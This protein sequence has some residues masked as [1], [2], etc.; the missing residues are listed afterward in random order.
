LRGVVVAGLFAA[1][2]STICT[3]LNT[4]AAYLINDV[5]KRFMVPN[6]DTKHYVRVGRVATIGVMIVGGYM[7]TVS[8][9]ILDLSQMMA[10]F[11]G[12]VGALFVLRWFWWRINAWSEITAY[13]S[14]GTLGMLVNLEAG[15]S[16][17][18]RVVGGLA[19]AS[20]TAKI[21][22]FFM[23]TLTGP[24]GWAFKLA[25]IA[26]L[27]T[28]ISLAVTLLTPPTEQAHLHRFY[29]IVKPYGPGW[30][31]VRRECGPVALH[32]GQVL[33]DWRRLAWGTVFFFSTFW[34]V[35]QLTLGNWKE[36]FMAGLFMAVSGGFLYRHWSRMKE[37]D[38][39]LP[40][41]ID[42]GLARAVVTPP[43]QTTSER[44]SD[45]KLS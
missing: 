21:D 4:N 20:A 10:Q 25:F 19:P 38:P 11:T 18:H 34:T 12:G 9:S 28:V 43:D 7:A 22:Q 2:M 5:Y 40:E 26:M 33:F 39:N 44:R 37:A 14:S 41:L 31:K 32:P 13:L 6:A 1:F 3:L 8:T 23:V 35:G 27:T 30:A 15:R 45:D 16:F 29:R 17:F 36:G 42:D 24:E